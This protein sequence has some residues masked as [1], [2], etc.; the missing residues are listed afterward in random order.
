MTF[1]DAWTAADRLIWSRN[2]AVVG[3]VVGHFKSPN[4]VQILS[5][6]S[7]LPNEL[8]PLT[9][10]LAIAPSSLMNPQQLGRTSNERIRRRQT[11]KYG[12]YGGSHNTKLRLKDF[13]A[14]LSPRVALCRV[15]PSTLSYNNFLIEHVEGCVIPHCK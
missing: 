13:Y 1:E 4:L 15:F 10:P 8:R 12:Y 6:S 14:V 2:F 5:P 7:F 3:V 11:G 9:P